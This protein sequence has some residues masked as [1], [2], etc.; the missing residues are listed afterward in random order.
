M[1]TDM[2]LVDAIIQQ[3]LFFRQI[4]PDGNGAPKRLQ[5][6]PRPHLKRRGGQSRTGG[7]FQNPF[8]SGAVKLPRRQRHRCRNDGRRRDRQKP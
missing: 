1:I 6:S 4:T 2:P 3:N 8:T 5:F 7:L